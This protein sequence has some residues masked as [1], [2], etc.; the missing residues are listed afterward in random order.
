MTK[1]PKCG[2]PEAYIGFNSIEC[3]NP[4]CEHFVLEEKKT[5]GCCGK[6]DHGVESCPS[7]LSE[8][9]D[10]SGGNGPPSLYSAGQTS[11]PPPDWHGD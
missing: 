3:R 1:C 5:C 10:D 9:Y 11:S 6:D 2:T 4:D 7:T 8:D